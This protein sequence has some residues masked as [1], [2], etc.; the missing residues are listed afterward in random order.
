M[1]VDDEAYAVDHRGA[2]FDLAAV[3]QVAPG[4]GAH[5]PTGSSTAMA[6]ET[7]F[8]QYWSRETAGGNPTS[9]FST[10]VRLTF[11]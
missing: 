2:P 5:G 1:G 10:A 7:R 6:G 3:V 11:Q 8:F 9:N 4:R